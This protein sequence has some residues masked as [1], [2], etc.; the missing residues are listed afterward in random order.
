MITLLADIGGTK[1]QLALM[2]H[3]GVLIRKCKVLNKEYR[4]IEG[5]IDEFLAPEMETPHYAVLAVA[6][7]VD[8]GIR[9]QMTNL[10]WLIDGEAL[11]E[12]FNLRSIALLNDLQATAW[13]MTSTSVQSQFTFLRR[14]RLNF[15]QP[16]VVISP[17][18]GLGQACIIPHDSSYCINATEGGHKSIAPFNKLSADLLH[19]HWQRHS[20]P[21]SWENWF[22]GSGFGHLYQAMFPNEAAPGN[23]VMS[24]NALS[25]PDSHCG[26]V[27]QLF[28][29]A[30][31]AE[32]GNLILQYLAWGGVIIA[33][34][35]PPKLEY[36]FNLPGNIDYIQRKNEYVDRLRAVPV[37]LSKNTDTPLEGAAQY[38]IKHMMN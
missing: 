14:N 35:I 25:N 11:R 16:I 3:S 38:C 8:D 13:G 12:R 21:P 22:S 36:F 18:T 34:G 6:G 7:P 17:G 27:M 19:Q 1:T 23:Q 20:F 30:I 5:V 37:A 28:T 32:C 9:C 15:D 29:Q 31:Y 2:N 24:D 10:P 26:Q 33:G 4:N